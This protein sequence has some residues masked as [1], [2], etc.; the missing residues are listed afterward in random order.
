MKH[1][2][3]GNINL[4]TDLTNL[5]KQYG[6]SNNDIFTEQNKQYNDLFIEGKMCIPKFTAFY[7]K[8]DVYARKY[9]EWNCGSGAG[10]IV[11]YPYLYY[12]TNNI[13]FTVWPICSRPI[14]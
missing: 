14:L 2:N 11:L 5:T 13:L 4:Q 8:D 3:N 9:L 10:N 1:E 12:D 7:S 6:Y